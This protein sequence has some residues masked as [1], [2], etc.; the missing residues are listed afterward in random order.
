MKIKKEVLY[1]INRLEQIHVVF[2][3]NQKSNHFTREKTHNQLKR[4]IF[5]FMYLKNTFYYIVLKNVDNISR[6]GLMLTMSNLM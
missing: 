6:R 5:I 3:F 2:F 1:N 4:Y